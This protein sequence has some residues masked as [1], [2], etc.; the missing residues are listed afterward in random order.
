[1]FILIFLLICVILFNQNLI[2]DH[3][4]NY[5]KIEVVPTSM[6]YNNL[7]L[8]IISIIYKCKLFYIIIDNNILI[9]DII[10]NKM[11]II[12]FKIDK[13]NIK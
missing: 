6:I 3:F 9:I 1:M 4:T 5:K 7:N 11:N 2:N 10:N 13:Y 12:T 8:N